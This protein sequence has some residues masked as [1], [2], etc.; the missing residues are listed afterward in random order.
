MVSPSKF[1]DWCHAVREQCHKDGFRDDIYTGADGI[2]F[3]LFREGVLPQFA[4]Q[5]A[6]SAEDD[7]D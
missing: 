4:I 1:H 6:L 3:E 2:L 7:N 5:E